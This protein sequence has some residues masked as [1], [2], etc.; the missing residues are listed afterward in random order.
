MSSEDTKESSLQSYALFETHRA[1]ARLLKLGVP[2][3]DGHSMTLQIGLKNARF[4]DSIDDLLERM[5]DP[6]HPNF[7]PHLNDDEFAQLIQPHNESMQA[8][9]DWL[10]NHGFQSDQMK[11][12]AHKDWVILEKVPLKKVEHMLNTTYFIYQDQGGEKMVRTEQYSLPESLHRHIELIQ[13]TTMFGVLHK[14]RSRVSKISQVSEVKSKRLLDHIPDICPGPILVTNGCLRQLYKTEGYEVQVPDRN[15]IATTGYLDE[16]ANLEDAQLFLKTQRSDQVGQSFDVILVNGG[17]NPQELN[18]EQIDKELGVEA[19]LDTQTT[20]GLTL[21]TRNVFYSVGGRPPFIADLGT[22]QNSNEP[23]LEWLQY[24]LGQPTDKLPKVISSSYGDEEQS[25]P[26]SYARRVCNGFA[27]LSARGVSLL[28]SSGD[29]GV[30]ESGTCY[31]N[32]EPRKRMFLPDFPA[33]CPYVTTV[34]G[35]ENFYPEVAV[36]KF[37]FAGFTSGGGFSNYFQIPEWQ[38]KA[39]DRY[40]QFLGPDEYKDLYNRTGRGYPDV[41]AQGSRYAIA[42]RQTFLSVDGTSASSPTFASII[43]LLNDYSISLGGPSLGYLNPWLYASGFKGLNDIT[44]GS[45]NGC[46]TSGFRAT[47]GWDPVNGLGT[48]DFQKLQ[49]LIR[50]WSLAMAQSQKDFQ[51]KINHFSD[52]LNSTQTSN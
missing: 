43:A 23:F 10:K 48:P 40:L 1:P 16:A 9:A 49:D 38:Q 24:M 50:P 45:A 44:F 27:A 29:F 2:P 36:S 26:L 7:R 41:S 52:R 37:G 6:A 46:N 39:V 35:T 4:E 12:T 17:S 47:E 33:S 42:W 34:G 51:K 28:F 19:N 25:V 8:V 3:R 13:P 32:T 21:P 20:L 31:S 14:Q 5:S 18:Q 11:W 15:M 22:P 30:G